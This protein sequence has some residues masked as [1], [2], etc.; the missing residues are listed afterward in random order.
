MRA[1]FKI[2]QA[3]L[4]GLSLF[5]WANWAQS[6]PR[7]WE[8]LQMHTS[9]FPIHK[10]IG[11]NCG[12]ETCVGISSLEYTYN[13]VMYD[14]ALD[15]ALK[16][17][18]K[19]KDV[20]FR[21]RRGGKNSNWNYWWVISLILVY[22]CCMMYY[23]AILQCI[24]KINWILYPKWISLLLYW[25]VYQIYHNNALMSKVFDSITVHFQSTI[26]L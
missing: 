21:N 10:D 1:Y 16:R 23:C 19:K 18:V 20:C 4:C 8:N 13:L 6:H 26:Q 9:T 15:V 17:M 11:S 14:R 3:F 2:V 24:T 7:E 25:K 12:I 22:Y 5:L